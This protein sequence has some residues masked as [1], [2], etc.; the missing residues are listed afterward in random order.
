MSANSGELGPTTKGGEPTAEIPET[1][2]P[3]TEH[4]SDDERAELERLR[5]E[6]AELHHGGATRPSRRR[7]SWR[8]LFATILIVLGCVLAP[9]SVVGV[10]A[11]NQIPTPAGTWPPCSR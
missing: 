8:A 6:N 11:G 5:A 1:R 9:I 3:A 10:W 7:F 2:E 4:L